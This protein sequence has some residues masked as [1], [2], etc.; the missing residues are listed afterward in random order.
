MRFII[1]VLAIFYCLMIPI[2]KAE[3]SINPTLYEHLK[4]LNA[5]IPDGFTV[6]TEP[7]F[8][9]IGNESPERVRYWA[10]DVV[11]WAVDKLKQ[12][13]FKQ[14]P[15]KIIDIWLFKDNDSYIKYAKELFNDTPTTPFGYYSAKDNSLIMN[16][17]TGG[18]TLVHELIHPFMRANLPKCPPW[19]NEGLASL[20]EQSAERNGHIVGLTNW[21]LNGLHQAIRNGEVISFETLTAMDDDTF[22]N[23]NDKGKYNDNYAQA[24]YLCYYLQEKGLLVKFYHEFA[25]NMK[26]DPTGYNTLKQVLDE[27]DMDA[28]KKK[29]ESFVLTL[30]FP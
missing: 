8:V 27:P 28:F 22:Y 18:G 15:N 26:S 17:A 21:R 12:D 10:I 30:R 2:G 19:F 5:K 29:W 24:R 6:V 1:V 16:V 14:D 4:Q 23:R 3:V 13:Y 11:R 9:V 7:P 20:Y 25:K